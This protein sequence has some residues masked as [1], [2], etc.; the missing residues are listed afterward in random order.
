MKTLCQALS[1]MHAKKV[2]HRDLKYATQ[3]SNPRL[4]DRVPGRP[5]THR[6]EPY[7]GQAGEHPLLRPERERRHP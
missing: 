1:Y 2:V 4:A 7:S 3:G 6:F 5:A